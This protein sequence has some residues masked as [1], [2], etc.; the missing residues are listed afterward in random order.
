MT[1]ALHTSHRYDDEL[2]QLRD[3]V[4]EMAERIAQRFAVATA[5][6]RSGNLA[7][8]ADMPQ[9][10]PEIM[11]LQRSAEDICDQILV[12]RQPVASDMRFV[13]ACIRISNDLERLHAHTN[14][15]AAATARIGSRDLGELVRHHGLNRALLLSHD[16]LQAALQA[17]K[18]GDTEAAAMLKNMDE[19]INAATRVIMQQQLTYMMEQP[20]TVA[21]AVEFMVIVRSIERIGDYA[22]NIA[23]LVKYMRMGRDTSQTQT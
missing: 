10:D 17:F 2:Q 20:K 19:E 11:H 7:D 9:D 3:C 14:K 16:M 12:R 4:I 1:L 8:L 23:K 6:M 13:V 15:I 21:S 5:P 18:S 22:K